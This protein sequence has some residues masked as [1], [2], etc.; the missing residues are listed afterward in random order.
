MDGDYF[1][2]ALRDAQ[3]IAQDEKTYIGSLPSFPSIWVVGPTEDIC[4]SRLLAGL[5]R[6]IHL[7]LLLGYGDVL[8]TF[9]GQRPPA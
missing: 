1:Q 4:R 3:I 6:L 5:K 2:A 9:D 7:D 8:P